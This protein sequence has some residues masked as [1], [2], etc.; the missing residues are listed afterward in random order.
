M[1]VLDVPFGTTEQRFWVG[2]ASCAVPGSP[3][4]LGEAHRRWGSLPWADLVAPA[5]DLARAGVTVTPQQATLHRMLADVLTSTP[6]A[7]AVWAPAG[8]CWPRA[9]CCASPAWRGA[10][11]VS[12]KPASTT[13]TTAPSPGRSPSTSARTAVPS[14]P[15]TSPP[16]G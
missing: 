14:V 8:R 12:P 9:R 1:E 11:S 13:S 10:W 16:T 6:E 4:G 15:T 2:A 5:I 3:L 7:A